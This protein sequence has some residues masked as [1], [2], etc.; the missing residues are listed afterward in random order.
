MLERRDKYR[1]YTSEKY[2]KIKTGEGRGREARRSEAGGEG[3]NRR[4]RR[5]ESDYSGEIRGERRAAAFASTRKTGRRRASPLSAERLFQWATAVFQG[6]ACV[7]ACV[8]VH[9]RADTPFTRHSP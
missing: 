2:G 8:L 9:V 6:C 7:C 4:D 1:G 5:K 3:E